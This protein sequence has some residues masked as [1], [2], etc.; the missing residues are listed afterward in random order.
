M[1]KKLG[2]ILAVPKI[3]FVAGAVLVACTAVPRDVH[4]QPNPAAGH[5]EHGKQVADSKCAA[6]HGAD[7]NGSDP[8]YPKLAGQDPAYLYQQLRNFR[9]GFRNS[10]VMSGIAATLSGA[11]A[12]DV[13]SFYARATMNRD[14]VKDR[15][16]AAAGERLFFRGSRA[17]PACAMCHGL[18]AGRGMMGGG[19]M[20]GRGMMG[21]G[22]MGGAEAP[23]VD[24]QHAAYLVDQL[25]QFASGRRPSPIM[26]RIAVALSEAD[27]KAVAEFLSGMP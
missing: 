16:A 19:G 21:G 14:A 17:G 10:E 8:R 9:S 18:G 7:G 11:D 12:A 6:C 25:N 4:A 1:T 13:A 24:G 20:M 5:P 26:G 23:K 22:M 3:A 15:A 2:G 27:R